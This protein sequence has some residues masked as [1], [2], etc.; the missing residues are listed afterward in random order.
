MTIQTTTQLTGLLDQV[1]QIIER[2]MR[3]RISQHNRVVSRLGSL[4]RLRPPSSA[5]EPK[6][7]LALEGEAAPPLTIP[8]ENTKNKMLGSLYQVLGATARLGQLDDALDEVVSEVI[9]RTEDT[10]SKM[11]EMDQ[12]LHTLSSVAQKQKLALDS[13]ADLARSLELARVNA[14]T[15]ADMLRNRLISRTGEVH[16]LERQLKQVRNQLILAQNAQIAVFENGWLGD[17]A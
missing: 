11:V 6:S 16:D 13:A 9:Q 12:R 3:H 14:V 5:N 8:I 2:Q 15:H 1:N 17:G 4:A 10:R 7:S